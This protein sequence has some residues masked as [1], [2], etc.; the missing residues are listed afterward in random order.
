MNQV[1]IL[2]SLSDGDGSATNEIL[3]C[4]TRFTKMNWCELAEPFNQV[5]GHT[6]FWTYAILLH[7]VLTERVR[8]SDCFLHTSH[9]HDTCP[10]P[11]E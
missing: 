2:S 8:S 3:G 1:L 9:K 11:S 4:T 10:L 7:E 6:I 5:K